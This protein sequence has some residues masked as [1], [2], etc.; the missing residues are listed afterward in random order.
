MTSGDR[1]PDLRSWTQTACDSES[2]KGPKKTTRW[3]VS[4]FSHLLNE[5]QG[6]E[7]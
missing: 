1:S 2:L 3:P 5:E 7:D 6:E 4:L